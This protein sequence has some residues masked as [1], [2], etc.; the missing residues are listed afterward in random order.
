M[1]AILDVAGLTVRFGDRAVVDGVSL[2]LDAGECLALVGESGSGKTLTSRALLGLVPAGGVVA[3]ERLE[4]VGHDGRAVDERGWRTIRGREAALVAQDALVS[5]DPLRRIGRE[6]GE[7]LVTHARRARRRLSRA[8]AREAVIEELRHVAIPEPELRVRQYAHQLSGGQRQRALVASATINRPR[9][10]IADEPT[11][12]LDVS[13]QRQVLLLLQRLKE[14]GA[15]L[16][17]ISHDLAVVARIADRVAVMR[18]GRIVEAGPTATVLAAPRHEYTRALLAAE[19][20]LHPRGTRL[21]SG[22]R[23]DL[24]RIVRREP[25]AA[26]SGDATALVSVE[27]VSK[28]FRRADGG[29]LR[30]VDDVSFE[31]APGTTLGIVGE[32]GS[33][34]TTLGRIVLGLEQPDAGAVRLEGRPWSGVPERDRRD[35]RGVIQS[36]YQ[37]ALSSFDPR[38]TVGA[39]LRE[40]LALT[41]VPR[42]EREERAVELVTRIGLSPDHLRRR[43]L[44]LSGGQRQR[45]AIA[46]ALARAPRVLVCDEPVSA[47]DVSIQA[48]VL[49][50]LTDVQQQL[51]LAMLF[52]SHDLGVIRH[53][54]DD[55]LVMRAGR[56]VERGP[57]EDVFRAPRHET[58]R[59]L[60]AALPASQLASPPGKEPA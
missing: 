35:R 5:L 32:S 57:A 56:V 47:L 45:V 48:Q 14:E 37:D 8:Q 17:L 55:V 33:G 44:T 59:E 15:G 9:L 10:L 34:K 1:N 36:V 46:R 25:P 52:I 54:C 42:G 60:L 53:M 28:S 11:T 21:S 22:D 41:G 2:R 4:V 30:A 27:G 49:D 51:G 18:E 29:R 50:A 13:V 58:T 12:A 20:S 23:L 24:A 19:P 38:A 43:P 3:A 26:A 31:L 6:V 39:I 16:L 40:A 7:S